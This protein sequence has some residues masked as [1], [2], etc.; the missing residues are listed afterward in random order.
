MT[1]SVLI[2]SFEKISKSLS[3]VI[4]VDSGYFNIMGYEIEQS[5]RIEMIDM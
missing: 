4:T 3:S 2:I 1:S 5:F